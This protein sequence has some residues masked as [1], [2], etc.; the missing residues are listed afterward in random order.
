MGTRTDRETT[1]ELSVR[2]RAYATQIWSFLR[3][4]KVLISLTSYSAL[5]V[6]CGAVIFLEMEIILLMRVVVDISSNLTIPLIP[7]PSLIY[8][9]IVRFNSGIWLGKN[10]PSV[11]SYGSVCIYS[12]AFRSLDSHFW[13]KFLRKICKPFFRALIWYIKVPIRNPR[14]IFSRFAGAK[15]QKTTRKS[16]SFMFFF[17]SL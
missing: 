16:S 8:S 11:V 4:T 12:V 3:P 6:T 1:T 2:F 15:I 7:T 13:Y 10:N 9:E 17:K 5:A 14:P